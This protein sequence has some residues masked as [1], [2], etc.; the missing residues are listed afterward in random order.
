[1]PMIAFIGV[2]I[3]WLMAAR[4]VLLAWFACSAASRAS[5]GRPEQP[6]VVDGDRR[7]LGE[8]DQEV[9]VGLVNG[10]LGPER[11]TAI[12]PLTPSRPMQR[13]DHQPLVP[14]TS[15]VPGIW[16]SAG[17]SAT[18]LTTSAA[19]RAASRR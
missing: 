19:P 2:R 12:M 14:A 18:S 3:S 15:S 1:M 8:A 4:N 16:T 11:Q 17:R 7:L 10:A 6:G 13:R 9:E 5:R